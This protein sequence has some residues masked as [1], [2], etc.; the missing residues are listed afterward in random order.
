[1]NVIVCYM[2]YVFV[3]VAV[4]YFSIEMVHSQ[5]YN[6]YW[7]NDY[8]RQF[9]FF[10]SILK[11]P[12]ALN[13]PANAF[14]FGVSLVTKHWQQRKKPKCHKFFKV[15]CSIFIFTL[16]FCCCFQILMAF[17]ELYFND[18]LVIVTVLFF[19]KFLAPIFTPFYQW[20]SFF[21]SFTNHLAFQAIKI[22]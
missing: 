7:F 16:D 13:L 20:M 4:S 18:D 17:N 8:V 11:F 21:F 9:I 2:L 14:L 10:Q 22:N 1:M 6:S 12:I 15:F 5:K 19:S 3:Y